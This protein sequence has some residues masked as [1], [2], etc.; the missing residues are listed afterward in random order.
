MF[1][2]GWGWDPKKPREQ[3]ANEPSQTARSIKD[4]EKK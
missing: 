4:V 2:H 1:S 3:L